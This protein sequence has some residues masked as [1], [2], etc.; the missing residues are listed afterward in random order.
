MNKLLDGQA[1]HDSD[2]GW[3]QQVGDGGAHE[4]RAQQ[5][6][7]ALL[8]DP[9]REPTPV[10][11]LKPLGVQVRGDVPD[12]YRRRPNRLTS[13]GCAA[14][15]QAHRCNLRVREDDLRPRATIARGGAEWGLR[16]RDLWELAFRVGGGARDDGARA[17]AAVVLCV[18]REDCATVDVARGV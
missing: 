12:R 9:L 15:R 2:R 5:H 10:R 18:V 8:D 4:G 1:A 16:R 11:I 14:P 6:A 3:V 13:G 17:N 7:R